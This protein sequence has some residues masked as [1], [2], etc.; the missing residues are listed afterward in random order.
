MRLIAVELCADII[1]YLERRPDSD[2]AKALIKQLTHLP[3]LRE[4]VPPKI[5][6]LEHEHDML[7]EERVCL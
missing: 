2:E 1:H 5:I 7:D 6:D 3:I 4:N